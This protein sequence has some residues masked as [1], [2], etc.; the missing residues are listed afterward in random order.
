MAPHLETTDEVTHTMNLRTRWIIGAAVFAPLLVGVPL[1]L[2][3]NDHPA[4]ARTIGVVTSLAV[5]AVI[6][7]I[8]PLKRH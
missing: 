2:V 8:N 6:L 7:A 4:I 3:Q 5:A 1:Y